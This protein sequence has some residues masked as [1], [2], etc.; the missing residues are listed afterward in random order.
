M[1]S[2]AGP[3]L[4]Y[5]STARS[6]SAC[7][8]ASPP[9]TASTGA[10]AGSPRRCLPSARLAPRCDGGT[11]RPT[12]RYFAPLRPAIGYA[13]YTRRARGARAARTSARSRASPGRRGK[14]ETEK[15]SSS[16]PA[17]GTSR[18]STRS[19]DP[20]NVTVAPRSRSA[21]A[22]AR[23][24][25]TC[26]AV[27]PAAIRHT[28]PDDLSIDGDVKEYPDPG[29]Q[30]D[31]ARPAVGDERQRDPGERSDAEDGRQVDRRLAADERREPGGEELA[32]R[33]LAAE[34]DAK[35]REGE[36][37]ERADDEHR[38]DETELLADHREDHV[39]VRLGEVEHLGDALPEALA[40]EASGAEADQRL[41]DLKA[42]AFRVA[43][44]VEEAED[45]GATVG[46]GP[47]RDHADP[48]REE[49][50]RE[51]R[52]ERHAGDEEDREHRPA[53]RDGRAEVG[54]EQDQP[55]EDRGQESERPRELAERLRRTPP[56]EVDGRE[57]AEGELRE[58]GGL[59]ARGAEDEPAL[60]AVDLRRHHEDGC[61]QAERD[62][63]ERGREVA[64]PVVVEARG[65]EHERDPEKRIDA[66]PLQVAH[67]VAVA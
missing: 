25:R 39:G 7:A 4:P 26:P 62:E 43:P 52:T 54:L 17:S 21:S 13:R 15:V 30:H 50:S 41:H 9:K 20:A 46:L 38:A 64:Q 28:G 47:D 5:V 34:R 18:D 2:T 10:S 60:R 1:C 14:P 63:E 44:G 66:L 49:C 42:R 32:E 19:G 51:Q 48:D 37:G 3:R 45:T 56:R 29:E 11:G 16:K 57:E 8:P 59:E 27:P 33:I 6:L 40:R 35:S 24:G 67:R 23:A 36:C 12:T 58:L 65:H 55:A 22:T 53:E 61:A 31:E